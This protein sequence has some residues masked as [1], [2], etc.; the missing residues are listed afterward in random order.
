[1]SDS[2]SK[3]LYKPLD[4][5]G[6]FIGAFIAMVWRQKAA[7]VKDLRERR[8]FGAVRRNCPLRKRPREIESDTC[9]YAQWQWI[10]AQTVA[11]TRQV[12]ASCYGALAARWSWRAATLGHWPENNAWTRD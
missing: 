7:G 2:F 3:R 8:S 1:M 6:Q 4:T 11:T 5:S 12:R 10:V 9:V